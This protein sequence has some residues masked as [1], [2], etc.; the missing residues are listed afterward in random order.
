MT[1]L[2]LYGA[3]D[4]VWKYGSKGYEFLKSKWGTPDT[5]AQA[6]NA[7]SGAAPAGGAVQAQQAADLA[8]PSVQLQTGAPAAAT[9]ATSAATGATAQ[10]A[11]LFAITVVVITHN[12]AL[13]PMGD[14]VIK[15]KSGLVEQVQINESPLSVEDLEW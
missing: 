6:A 7:G 2:S 10:E 11:M 4:Q 13:M 8:A 1:G 5:A 3:G 12:L 14:K 9:D 15:L